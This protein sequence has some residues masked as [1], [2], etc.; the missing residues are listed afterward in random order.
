MTLRTLAISLSHF[1]K[2]EKSA[3]SFKYLLRYSNALPTWDA[4]PSRDSRNINFQLKDLMLIDILDRPNCHRTFE[5]CKIFLL[6]FHKVL[7]MIEVKK[8]NSID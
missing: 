8:V 4:F 5:W 7:E 3:C 1:A 6:Q 2:W